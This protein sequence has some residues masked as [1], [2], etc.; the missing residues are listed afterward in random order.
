MR[1]GDFGGRRGWCAAALAALAVL[2]PAPGQAAPASPCAG[3]T[4]PLTELSAERERAALRCL[5]SQRRKA[6]RLPAVKPSKPLRGLARELARDLLVSGERGH[7]TRKG[8]PLARRAAR[9]LRSSFRSRWEVGE[10]LSWTT[11]GDATPQDLFDALVRSRPHRRILDDRRY[12][13]ADCAIAAA[14]TDAVAV[15]E[16]ARLR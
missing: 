1:R 15:V 10:V 12:S 3:A 7:R 9:H 14:G 11:G 5:V 8:E 2:L 16:L 13:L 6:R 4:R